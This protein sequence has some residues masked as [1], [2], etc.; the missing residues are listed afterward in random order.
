MVFRS[1]GNWIKEQTAERSREQ[2]NFAARASVWSTGS[3]VKDC[4]QICFI[5]WSFLLLTVV[6]GS[7]ICVLC[8]WSQP[9]QNKLQNLFESLSQ[10]EK[11]N[12]RL[13]LDLQKMVTKLAA[14]TQ[15]NM[16]LKTQLGSLQLASNSAS[17]DSNSNSTFFD[18]VRR[19]ARLS[20]TSFDK[21]LSGIYYSSLF[22]RILDRAWFL[23]CIFWETKS[24]CVSEGLE[25]ND[26]AF[27]LI[28]LFLPAL[29]IDFSRGGTG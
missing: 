22:L 14:E 20:Y 10:K 12:I 13:E 8:A 5:N 23:H 17:K 11:E 1:S 15:S 9:P 18:W 26:V 4:C 6:S 21:G 25:M 16:N 28:S 27:V 24:S 7:T 19:A 3:K 2:N 29:L